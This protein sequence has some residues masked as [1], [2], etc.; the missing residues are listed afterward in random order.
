LN[1]ADNREAKER[2]RGW[3][4]EKLIN[5]HGISGSTAQVGF[6]AVVYTVH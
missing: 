5:M 2:D 3:N 1:F 4:G 6:L